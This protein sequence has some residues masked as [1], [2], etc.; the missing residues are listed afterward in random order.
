MIL[1][2]CNFNK[3][4]LVAK[5]IKPEMRIKHGSDAFQGYSLTIYTPTD[6][7]QMKDNQ[8]TKQHC[9]QWTVRCVLPRTFPCS[10]LCLAS[11]QRTRGQPVAD[12]ANHGRKI[13]C[14]VSINS[15]LNSKRLNHENT[16]LC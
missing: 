7:V 13:L 6:T 2:F 12:R 14:K 5:C 3:A 1:K 11:N 10:E 16:M 9:E 8:T 4:K 15:A